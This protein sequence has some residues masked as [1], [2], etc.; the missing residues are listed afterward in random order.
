MRNRSAERGL[1]RQIN[2]GVNLHWVSR[3]RS[4]LIDH[5][6]RDCKPIGYAD[7]RANYFRDGFAIIDRHVHPN[8]LRLIWTEH[9]FSYLA[10]QQ[11]ESKPCAKWRG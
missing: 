7:F 4:E 10:C 11:C 3:Q 2:I 6:L 9:M 1:F 5:V 8:F